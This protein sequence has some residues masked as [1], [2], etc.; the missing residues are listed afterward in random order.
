MLF[1]LVTPWA[2]YASQGVS[3]KPQKDSDGLRDPQNSKHCF[4]T[5]Y[6]SF[7]KTNVGALRAPESGEK[8]THEAPLLPPSNTQNATRPPWT[9]ISPSSSIEFERLRVQV[10]RAQRPTSPGI[11][12]QSVTPPA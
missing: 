6:I 9:T 12:R 4:N 5:A 10:R 2:E 3:Q 1:L 11:D 8:N 7:R